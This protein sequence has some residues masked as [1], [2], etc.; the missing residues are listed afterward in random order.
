MRHPRTRRPPTPPAPSSVSRLVGATVLAVVV[1]AVA[2]AMSIAFGSRP[3][4]IGTVLDVL[5][6]P[7]RDDEVTLIVIGTRVPRTL[8]G[9][10][11]G[12]ALGVAG[13]V[14]QGVTRNPLADPSILGINSGAA[15]AVVVGIAVFGVSGTV[16][17]LPFA[18]AGAALAALLVYGVAAAA[19]RGITPVGLALSGAVVAAALASITTAVLVTSNTLLDQLRFWQVGSLSG[20]GIGAAATIA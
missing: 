20:R 19:R 2:C 1:L 17:Y 16:A 10:L 4:A 9:L 6:H 11:A 3:I 8:V 5:A 7:H 13:A 14:M 12:A 18:F 15:L